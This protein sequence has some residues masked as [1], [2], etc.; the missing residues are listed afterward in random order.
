MEG[1]ILTSHD[2]AVLTL[3]GLGLTSVQARV[4]LALVRTGLS[5]VRTNS[6][7]SNVARQDIYRIMTFLQGF[8]LVERAVSKPVMFKAIPIKDA[9]TILMERRM[10]ET[11]QLQVKTAKLIESFE[12]N[13]VEITIPERGPQF[14]LIPKQEVLLETARQIKSAKM[15][16]DV[17]ISLKMFLP[18]LSTSVELYEKA[19]KRG[20]KIRL[21][22]NESEDE[23]SLPEVVQDLKKNKSFKIKYLPTAPQANIRL[24]DKKLAHINTSATAGLAETPCYCTNNPSLLYI[25]RDYFEILWLTA[26]EDLK[27]KI[28]TSF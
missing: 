21:I 8:S 25:F 7:V 15:S 13:Y 20:V 9:V 14:F 4:Y 18:W 3:I 19:M 11:H 1:H 23:K 2:E 5:T 28:E 6:K 24:Y 22:I 12:R 26:L 27:S 17:V 16:L 10:K